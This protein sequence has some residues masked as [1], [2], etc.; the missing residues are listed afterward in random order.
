MPVLRA[1][2]SSL[3]V[4][5]PYQLETVSP[6]RWSRLIV[7]YIKERLEQ[8]SDIKSYKDAFMYSCVPNCVDY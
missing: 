7:V 1:V 6:T 2:S 5:H 4:T 3:F 8:C